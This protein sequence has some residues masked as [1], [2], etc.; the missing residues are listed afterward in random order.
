MDKTK[1]ASAPRLSLNCR[2]LFC[3]LVFAAFVAGFSP[4]LEAATF[5]VNTLFD[6][7]SDPTPNGTCANGPGGTCTLREAIVE[8]NALGGTNTINISITGTIGLN[9]ILQNLST[10]MSIAGPGAASLTI[11][12][13][14][15][16]F[17]IF[18]VTGSGVT[19]N[20]SGVT[21]S[22]GLAQGAGNGGGVRNS[23]GATANLTNCTVTANQTNNGNGAGI[24]NETGATMTLTGVTVS[25]NTAFSSGNGGGIYNQGSLTLTNCTVSGNTSGGV[26]GVLNSGTLNISGSVIN[27]NHGR[28]TGG[29]S[30]SNSLTLNTSTVSGNDIPTFDNGIG[31]LELSGTATITNCTI[32]GNTTGRSGLAGGIYN[33]GSLTVKNTTVHGNTATIAPQFFPLSTGGGIRNANGTLSV[34]SCTITGNA[35]DL[36]GGIITSAAG[37]TLRNSILADNTATT[38]GPDLDGNFASDGYNLIRTPTDAT[39][40]PNGGAGPDTTGLDPKLGPL[41]NNGGSTFTRALLDGSPAIDK[42]DDGSPTATTDQ[43]GST[44]PVDLNNS[45]YP[46]VADGSDIGA[47]EAQTVPPDTTPPTVTINQASGQADP[48]NA[49]PINFTVVF[50][51]SV[52][53]FATGDVTLSGT[54]GATTATVTGSGTTYNVAVTGMTTNGTV[55]ATINAGVATDAAGNPNTASTSTDNT[56]TY[57]ATRPSV[58]INQASGQADPANASGPI[59]FTVVFSESV[60]NFATGDVNLSGSA[61]ATTGTVTGSGTTYNVAVSGMTADGTVIATVS[62]GAA[63]DAAG[64][65]N[66][67]STSTDN[68]VTFDGTAPVVSSISRAVGAQNPTD[69]ATVDFVVVFSEAVS[70]VDVNDFALTTDGTISGATIDN[71][72]SNSASNYTVTVSTGTGS[73]TIRLDVSDNDS[74]TDTAGNPLGGPGTGNGDFTNGETYTI[75][76]TSPT[77]TIDQA[78]GQADPTDAA[79]INFTAVFSKPVTGFDAA[80]IQIT[81]TA[82]ANNAVVTEI[83]PNDSTTFNVAVSGM[84]QSGTVIAAIQAN[85]ATDSLGHPSDASTSTD[86]TVTFDLSALRILSITKNPSEVVLLCIGIPG[87]YYVAV[88]AP[89]AIGPYGNPSP[90]M[91]ADGNGL[92]EYHDGTQPQPAKRFYYVK[93][94]TGP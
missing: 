67:A 74:I 75:D 93:S 38:S 84:N 45:L 79:P 56:V 9:S 85:A 53:N 28:F 17:T 41:Q 22:N 19:V 12:R 60:S 29:V 59:N 80:D 57:D 49:G 50:S 68:T 88:S 35:A 62:S 82:D 73:G 32:S 18:N 55:I 11:S 46:N 37:T 77:V 47:Y 31:G 16:V 94:A 91:Q 64:N 69:A 15:N 25:S 63:T 43:R 81:G 39:I 71:V 21:I 86:N 26:G 58:T 8:A 5:T 7:G 40:T 20:I 4:A 76:K 72:A 92:F 13:S 65:T 10:S 42:G 36:G 1:S 61:G 2:K 54:A 52:S 70:G 89:E 51:E 34:Q 27:G 90:P 44:R 14:Q 23:N 48:T 83:A 78:A 87:N 24:S 66:T 30:S 3:L 33:S 6:P